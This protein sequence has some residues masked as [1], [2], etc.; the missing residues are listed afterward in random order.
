MQQAVPVFVGHG[1]LEFDS[2]ETGSH[3]GCS[4][5]GTGHRT[6]FPDS[7]SLAV[8]LRTDQRGASS[9]AGGVGGSTTLQVGDEVARASG[10][11]TP[12][13]ER[14]TGRASW[15]FPWTGLGSQTER[16]R[17]RLYGFRPQRLEGESY[18]SPRRVTRKG[19][20]VGGISGAWLG[21]HVQVPGSY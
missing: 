4:A 21:G 11:W 14:P 2:D 6:H 18:R 16:A 7:V 20:R 8:A 1:G 3:P 15:G 5:E 19:T 10:P 12:R 17:G 13:P 9:A